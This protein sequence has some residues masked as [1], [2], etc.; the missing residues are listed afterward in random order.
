MLQDSGEVMSEP[1]DPFK[2][3]QKSVVVSAFAKPLIVDTAFLGE[4][5]SFKRAQEI[6]RC[7]IQY[8]WFNL[9]A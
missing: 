5:V 9:S 2:P 7:L 6:I 1:S 4:H 3:I 8:F